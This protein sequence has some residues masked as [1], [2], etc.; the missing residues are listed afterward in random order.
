MLSSLYFSLIHTFASSHPNF[1][2]VDGYLSQ[3]SLTIH[4]T[5]PDLLTMQLQGSKWEWK[6]AM[7]LESLAHYSHSIFLLHSTNQRFKEWGNRF[8]LFM[9]G[10]ETHITKSMDTGSG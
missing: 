4:Q 2:N 3:M 6:G 10:A 1:I 8:H 7:P 5:S 9:G